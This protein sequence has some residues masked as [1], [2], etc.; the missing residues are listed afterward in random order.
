MAYR[1]YTSDVFTTQRFGGNPLA[2]F[3]DARG[4]SAEQMQT[5][6]REFNL[7]ETV[8]ILPPS[9]PANSFALRIFTPA[10]ELPFAGH[11]TIGAALMLLELGMVQL[12]DGKQSLRLEEQ[13][14]L[15]Q[16]ELSAQAGQPPS[17]VLTAAKLPEVGPP[18]PSIGELTQLLGLAEGDILEGEFAPE[19]V[20]C[21][22]GFLFV[23]VRDLAALG[24][25]RINVAIWEELLKD[26][27][28]PQT[29]LFTTETGQAGI[30]ARARMFAPAMGISEDPATGAAASAFAGYLAARDERREGTLNW[31]ILQGV[32]MGRP[33]T[34]YLSAELSDGAVSAVRVAGNAVLVSEGLFHI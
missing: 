14:G 2:V 33:S 20:S 12:E 31:T 30:A 29:F 34:L 4:L 32:E 22:V 6:A 7:S 5:I 11:P 1:F 25:A 9:D 24:R 23:P 17:A 3:P 21:G 27:W 16:V 28:A 26:Y 19:A 15:I 8:F 10:S 13:V 18:P